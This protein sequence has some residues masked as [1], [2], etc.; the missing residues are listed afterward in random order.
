MKYVRILLFA[1]LG[2]SAFAFGAA[3][4]K[5]F[6]GRN[7]SAPTFTCSSDILELPCDHTEKDLLA[8]ITA[9]D[10]DLTDKILV[11]AFSRFV[12]E[13]SCSVAY[14]VFDSAN[15]AATFNRK[16]H[17][18]DY[19]PPKIRLEE[20]LV[21]AEGAGSTDL[22]RDRLV[23]EDKLDGSLSEAAQF[24]N[25]SVYYDFAGDYSLTVTATNSFG[26]VVEET[27]P[28]H[29]IPK[30]EAELSF[31]LAEPLTYLKVGEAFDPMAGVLNVLDMSGTSYDPA[32]HVTFESDVNTVVPG[33]YEVHYEAE[34]GGGSR[35]QTWRTVIVEE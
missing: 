26:D 20:P 7:A 6:S 25:I 5:E 16:V 30:R 22:V 23:I 29:I 8:G 35:G 33:V 27:L 4:A 11:G 28:V 32:S 14:V 24:S 12:G 2:I 9:H 10:R 19:E 21:F 1:L 17:F 3:K 18:T 13:A 31:Q 34:N 15:A